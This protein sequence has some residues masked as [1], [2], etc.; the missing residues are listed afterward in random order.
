MV[1]GRDDEAPVSEN[2]NEL[3][4]NQAEALDDQATGP[5]EL[6][7]LLSE[8]GE[9]RR[10]FL[11]QALIVSGGLAAASLLSNYDLN[12]RAQSRSVKGGV[13]SRVNP[14]NLLPITLRLNGK[15]Y[16]LQIQP[17]VTLLDA[18]RERI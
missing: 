16:P 7:D 3:T 15:S 4:P 6:T 8:D 9:A 11:K 13:V 14:E 5:G 12:A 18:I 1:C 2:N 10:R 17:Q